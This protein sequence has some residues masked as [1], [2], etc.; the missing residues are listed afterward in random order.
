MQSRVV[1]IAGSEGQVPTN[2]PRLGGLE[3]HDPIVG[4]DEICETVGA[5]IFAV[6]AVEILIGD[7]SGPSTWKSCV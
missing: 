6:H 3:G 1:D 7:P 5:D 4:D 2:S